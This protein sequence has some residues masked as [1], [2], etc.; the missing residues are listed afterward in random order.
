MYGYQPNGRQ[1]RHNGTGNVWNVAALATAVFLCSL[2]LAKVLSG[3][4]E[5]EQFA[6]SAYSA[7][8]RD[9]LARTEQSSRLQSILRSVGVD[10]VVTGTITRQGLPPVSPCGEEKG[11]GKSGK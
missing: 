1:P 4:V 5:S 8:I 9:S 7:A 2:L 6:H 11:G 10:R 3:M